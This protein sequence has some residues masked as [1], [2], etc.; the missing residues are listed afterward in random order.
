MGIV[1]ICCVSQSQPSIVVML[2][3]DIEIGFHFA[4]HATAQK[5]WTKPEKKIVCI[6][7]AAFPTKCIFVRKNRCDLIG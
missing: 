1:I 4:R 3:V 7:N 2:V 6:W 5:K